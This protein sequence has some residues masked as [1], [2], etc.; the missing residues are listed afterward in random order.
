MRG[1]GA[2]I[3]LFGFAC[4]RRGRRERILDRPVCRGMQIGRVAQSGPIRGRGIGGGG[5]QLSGRLGR[6]LDGYAVVSWV[7]VGW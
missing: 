5:G 1:S 6:D 4:F 2:P 7:P 3:L